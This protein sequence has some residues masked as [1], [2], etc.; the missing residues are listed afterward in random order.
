MKYLTKHL[1]EAAYEADASNLAKP[2]VALTVDDNKV[3]YMPYTPQPHI[4]YTIECSYNVESL[5]EYDGWII[6]TEESNA[7]DNISSLEI[8][9]VVQQSIISA[10]TTTGEHTVRITFTGTTQII[11]TTFRGC[12]SLT[13]T[14]IPNNVTNIGNFAF[15]QCYNL[16]SINIP[17]SVTTIGESA[18]GECGFLESA[19]I[20]NSITYIGNYV[21]GYCESLGSVTI[22]S[23]T[24]PQIGEEIFNYAPYIYVPSDSVDT[25][26]A[27]EGWSNYASYI[28][29]IP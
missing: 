13:S 4:E 2:H 18:F 12:N 1:T 23:T 29:A 14:T 3:H 20:G 10:F 22:T 11:D 5:G 16:T 24:P 7:I 27:A 28:E 17:N 15:Y 6:N 8:D 26:K 19:T 21:F 25:Y 9:G